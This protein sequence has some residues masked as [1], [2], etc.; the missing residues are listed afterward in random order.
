MIKVYIS[1]YE[2]CR[3]L[4]FLEAPIS[5][6]KFV[7]FLWETVFS[8]II[9]SIIKKLMVFPKKTYLSPTLTSSQWNILN[10]RQSYDL[11]RL[12]ISPSTGLQ[13]DNATNLKMP[14][15]HIQES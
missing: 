8:E 3:Q 15:L 12:T 2:K 1:Y 11:A 4:F 9:F 7:N 13:H 5:H 6:T 10:Y 14:G